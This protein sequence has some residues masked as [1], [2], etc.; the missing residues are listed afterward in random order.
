MVAT[1]RVTYVVRADYFGG[2]LIL[3]QLCNQFHVWWNC[4]IEGKKCTITWKRLTLL[5]AD[6]FHRVEH[7]NAVYLTQTCYRNVKSSQWLTVLQRSAS[8]NSENLE[9]NKHT[10]LHFCTYTTGGSAEVCH[11]VVMWHVANTP[12]DI[13]P[14]ISLA[15]ISKA[16]AT[17][18][19]PQTTLKKF[20]LRDMIICICLFN[21]YSLF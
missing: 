4:I 8:Y 18:I 6:S 2:F 14:S 19:E 10:G 21:S 7:D 13:T 20:I 12:P 11:A 17:G 3:H 15:Y 1:E 5:A 16:D 9:A